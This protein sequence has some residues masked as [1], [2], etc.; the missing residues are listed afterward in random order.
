M[1]R[2]TKIMLSAGGALLI[3]S[4]VRV[5]SGGVLLLVNVDIPFLL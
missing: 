5:G 4:G 3:G 1:K 2:F